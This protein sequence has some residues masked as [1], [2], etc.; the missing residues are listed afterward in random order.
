MGK[1][2][3]REIF[4]EYHQESS[5]ILTD[6]QYGETYRHNT[7]PHKFLIRK[8]I[9]SSSLNCSIQDINNIASR[10]LKLPIQVY[11]GEIIRL[12]E[13]EPGFCTPVLATGEVAFRYCSTKLSKNSTIA[14]LNLKDSDAAFYFIKKVAELG[15]RLE[16]LLEFFPR[17][18]LDEI[19]V[20][21]EG[22]MFANPYQKDYYVQMVL[23]VKYTLY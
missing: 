1:T 3:S 15:S 2:F 12:D 7:K 8:N 19:F 18:T 20:D 11:K 23:N 13:S 10:S 14:G 5:L 22:I 6:N 17:V 21:D 16:D 4:N 9:S